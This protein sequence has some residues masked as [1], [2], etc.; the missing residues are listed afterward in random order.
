VELWLSFDELAVELWLNG[1]A[2]RHGIG[3]IPSNKTKVFALAIHENGGEI[4]RNRGV[5][6]PMRQ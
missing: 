4:L 3:P 5:S 1:S 6:N 2:P